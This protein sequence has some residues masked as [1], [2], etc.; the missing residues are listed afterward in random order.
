MLEQS[1]DRLLK[2]RF[3]SIR[4][5]E[6][7]QMDVEALRKV[8]ELPHPHREQAFVALSIESLTNVKTLIV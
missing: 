8:L 2:A 7:L 5:N 4:K 6:E 3:I 1:Y